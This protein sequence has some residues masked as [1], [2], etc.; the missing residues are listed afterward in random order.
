MGQEQRDGARRFWSGTELG[1]RASR[2]ATRTDTISQVPAASW[3][4]RWKRRSSPLPYPMQKPG[5]EDSPTERTLREGQGL[6]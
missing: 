1:W 6:C 5:L 4:R 2:M 3:C